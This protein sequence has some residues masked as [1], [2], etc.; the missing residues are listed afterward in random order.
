M[1]RT[2]YPI[3]ETNSL[4]SEITS[5]TCGTHTGIFC[6]TVM[7]QTPYPILETNTLP[8]FGNKLLALG[9]AIVDIQIGCSGVSIR[10][11]HFTNQIFITKLL[12]FGIAITGI[13]GTQQNDASFQLYKHWP[14]TGVTNHASYKLIYTFGSPNTTFNL[15]IVPLAILHVG[16]FTSGPKLQPWNLCPSLTLF[17]WAFAPPVPNS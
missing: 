15:G 9:S 10:G 1:D 14:A 6:Y 11:E 7:H 16:I 12:Y 13:V 5:V 17:M 2:P 4:H 8:H 3:L